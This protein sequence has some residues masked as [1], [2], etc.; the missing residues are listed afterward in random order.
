M[1][2]SNARAA[3]DASRKAFGEHA[4]LTGGVADTLVDCLIDQNHLDEASK[5]LATIEPQSVAQLVGVPDWAATLDLQRSDIS[6]RR[7]DYAS[8][9][10]QIQ[11]AIPVFTRTDA[12]PYQKQRLEHLLPE[13]KSH[14][15]H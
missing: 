13:I 11:P 14:T 10:K 3:F 9:E 7:G 5:L 12:E 4:G 6:V 2:A 15:A 1:G 8:A